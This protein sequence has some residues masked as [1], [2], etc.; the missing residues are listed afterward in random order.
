MSISYSTF[1]LNI[2]PHA[3]FHDNKIY[4]L[5]SF[6]M[7]AWC[8]FSYGLTGIRKLFIKGPYSNIL[9]FVNCK[10]P[11]TTIL[12]SCGAKVA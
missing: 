1:L 9:G 6:L 3:F 4:L 8:F 2:M 10:V 11:L 7:L 12:L 5:I